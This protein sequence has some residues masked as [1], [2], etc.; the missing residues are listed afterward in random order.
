MDSLVLFYILSHG[1]GV[2]KQGLNLFWVWGIVNPG[3]RKA[4]LAG[5]AEWQTR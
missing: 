2:V 4:Q 3:L 5:V 1:I